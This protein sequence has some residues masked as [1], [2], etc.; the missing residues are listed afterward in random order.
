MKDKHYLRC[1]APICQGDPN[2]NYK[3][4]VLWYPGELVCKRKP[5]EKFQIKQLE[6]NRLTKK[7]RFKNVDKHYTA[8]DLEN[9]SL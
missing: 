8:D 4:E 9:S 1:E 2:L 7:G 5:Y 6:I 3:H